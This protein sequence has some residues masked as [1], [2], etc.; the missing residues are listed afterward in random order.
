MGVHCIHSNS[1]IVL[2]FSADK[3]M[4]DK[5]AQELQIE[6]EVQ[7]ILFAG[8]MILY[9]KYPKKIHQ[10][11]LQTFSNVSEYKSACKIQ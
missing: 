4:K 8:D 7:L 9:L 3:S 10:I 6:K 2:E 1:I 11:F 5:G